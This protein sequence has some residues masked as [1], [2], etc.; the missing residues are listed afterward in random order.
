MPWIKIK[1]GDQDEIDPSQAIPGLEFLGDTEAPAI[2]NNYQE[3]AGTDG[4][5]FNYATYS[6]NTIN[7]NFHLRFRNWYNLKLAQHDIYRLLLSKHLI[8][9]RTDAEPAIVKYVRAGNFEI[10]PT[11]D[12]SSSALFTVP[13]DNP[14]G[15]KYSLLNSD[16]LDSFAGDSW[17]MG[18]NL[19]SNDTLSYH[20]TTSNFKVFNAS[21]ITIDPYYQRHELSI[22]TKYTGSYLQL[23]NTTNNTSW[24]LNK[25]S[26]GGNTV[27]LNGITTTIDGKPAS[28]LTDYGNLALEPG[29]NNIKV[30]GATKMS[31]TFSFPF[32]YLG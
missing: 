27:I 32:I 4:S 8:R 30:S 21:D 22:I 28:N 23:T 2:T 16:K 6:K 14:S 26:K 12:G 18:M 20:F 3:N 9:I 13:F 11:V 17:Q 15:Y 31:I 19:P 7:A 10:K 25:S 1:V 29:Y 5:I 24:R